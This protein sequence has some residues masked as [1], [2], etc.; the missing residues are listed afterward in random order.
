MFNTPSMSACPL[1]VLDGIGAILLRVRLLA[2][3]CVHYFCALIRAPKMVSTGTSA[4]PWSACWASAC[5][6]AENVPESLSRDARWVAAI[7]RKRKE[8]A[9]AYVV[10]GIV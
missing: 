8:Q 4:T 5:S 2:T 3:S 7:E 1:Y 9:S 6:T 10:P